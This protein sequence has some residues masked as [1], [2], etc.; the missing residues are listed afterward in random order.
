MRDRG[1]RQELSWWSV[2]WTEGKK[3]ARLQSEILVPAGAKGQS[4]GSKMV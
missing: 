3:G 2:G 1:S 4:K